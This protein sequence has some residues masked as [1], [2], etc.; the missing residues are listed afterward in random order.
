[1]KF[2]WGFPAQQ[3]I[4][5]PANFRHLWLIRQMKPGTHWHH[6][7]VIISSYVWWWASVLYS[8]VWTSGEPHLFLR[9]L[10]IYDPIFSHNWFES[11]SI[12]LFL[13]LTRHSSTTNTTPHNRKSNKSFCLWLSNCVP[14]SNCNVTPATLIPNY[15]SQWNGL[16][17]TSSLVF[18]KTSPNQ[19]LTREPKSKLNLPFTAPALPA[20]HHPIKKIF[21]QQQLKLSLISPSIS[22]N[23]IRTLVGK[24]M[25]YVKKSQLFSHL[26]PVTPLP[27]PQG[28]DTN[29]CVQKLSIVVSQNTLAL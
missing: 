3:G 22:S 16:S 17:P 4:A 18:G 15:A 8:F 28:Q 7:L 26:S 24:I 2:S 23:K 19:S 10:H 29:T 21:M 25:F 9:G 13:S 11:S 27:S 6:L 12:T 1:M 5:L 14:P 20:I